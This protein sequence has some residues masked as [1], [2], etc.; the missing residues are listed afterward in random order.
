MLATHE[1][2]PEPNTISL[3]SSL[4]KESLEV[5][6]SRRRVLEVPVASFPFVINREHA[7]LHARSLQ[8]V[9][10]FG[11][12]CLVKMVPSSISIDLCAPR[13]DLGSESNGRFPFRV[14]VS[15]DDSSLH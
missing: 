6:Q 8:L 4:I 2:R 15:S 13:T 11:Q 12:E 14:L 9:I 1:C 3:L 10:E 7:S 5:R